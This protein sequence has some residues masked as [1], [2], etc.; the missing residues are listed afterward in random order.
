MLRK[1]AKYFYFTNFLEYTFKKDTSCWIF[2]GTAET[3]NRPSMVKIA[4][5]A[6]STLQN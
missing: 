6:I 1:L 3:F 5:F 4:N 2:M